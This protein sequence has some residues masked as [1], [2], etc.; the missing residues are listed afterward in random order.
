M[1]TKLQEKTGVYTK[2]E[3]P[4]DLIEYINGAGRLDQRKIVDILKLV[5]DELEALKKE[6]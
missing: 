4:S 1:L 3:K 6:K 5:V 2:F